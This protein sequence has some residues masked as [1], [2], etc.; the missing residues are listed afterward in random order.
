M[1]TVYINKMKRSEFEKK[2]NVKAAPVRSL[3][4][5]CCSVVLSPQPK[6]LI[7]VRIMISHA[8]SRPRGHFFGCIGVSNEEFDQ[9]S[10]IVPPEFQPGCI[11][12]TRFEWMT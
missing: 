8:I 1:M 12:T 7:L 2:M 4:A 10:A 5:A 9:V 3:Y 11:E 6:Q